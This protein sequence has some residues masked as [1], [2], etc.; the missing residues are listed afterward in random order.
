MYNP[1]RFRGDH[2]VTF[3][4][5]LAQLTAAGE[6]DSLPASVDRFAVARLRGEPGE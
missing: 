4:P 6:P 1:G 2:L 3:F 5:T